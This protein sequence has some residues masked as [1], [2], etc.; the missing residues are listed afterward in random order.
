MTDFRTALDSLGDTPF[1]AYLYPSLYLDETPFDNE[2]KLLRAL[3]YMYVIYDSVHAPDYVDPDGSFR[4]YTAIVQDP[5]T[6]D[7]YGR[8]YREYSG[9]GG[10]DTEWVD[11]DWTLYH[12]HKIT[13]TQYLPSCHCGDPVTFGYDGD[14]THTRGLCEDCDTVRCDAYPGECGK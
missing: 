13:V 3:S 1:R 8:A 4:E 12:R 7:Y 14:P 10:W 2:G 5:Q 11:P 6:E 9:M